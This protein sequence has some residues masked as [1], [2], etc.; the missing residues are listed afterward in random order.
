MSEESAKKLREA[1]IR[2]DEETAK[3]IAKDLVKTELDPLKIIRDYLSPAMRVVG[4]KF[5]KGEYFLMH[6]MMAGEAMEAV[7]EILTSAMEQESK[8]KLRQEREK[9][10][11]IVIGTVLGDIHDIG[12]NIVSSLLRANGYTV[13][14]VGK[15]VAPKKFVEKAEEVNAD[16]IALSALLT[17]TLPYQGDVINLLKEK[18][19]REKYKVIVGGGPTTQEWADE[20]GADGWAPDAIEAM[21]SVKKL[22]G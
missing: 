1:I 6:L 7:T 20:I 19:L 13:F 14:D 9:A 22:I 11:K 2:G 3:D 21:E 16:M 17:V 8:E 12:K 18:G 5:E 10:K 4:E 15:D